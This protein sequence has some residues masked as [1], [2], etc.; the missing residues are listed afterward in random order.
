MVKKSLD[1]VL[2]IIPSLFEINLIS[3]KDGNVIFDKLAD[4]LEFDEGF[5]YFINPDSLQLKY[6]YKQHANYNIN[7]TF[8]MLDSFKTKLF[9]KENE[10]LTSESD[11]IK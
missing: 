5:I 11:L 4:I 7:Q 8:P 10:I 3:D 9:S 1:E 2:K 6:S